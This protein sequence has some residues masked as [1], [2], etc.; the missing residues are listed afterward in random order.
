MFAQ[1]AQVDR[2]DRVD[3]VDGVDGVDAVCTLTCV[4]DQESVLYM[5]LVSTYIYAQTKERLTRLTG[6]TG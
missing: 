1:V 3:G 2:V 5:F 6:L 4:G